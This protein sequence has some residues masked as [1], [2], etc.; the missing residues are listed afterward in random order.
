MTQQQEENNHSN[1]EEEVLA[2][3]V[4][5]V[6]KK[7]GVEDNYKTQLCYECRT[8]LSKF[9]IPKSILLFLLVIVI[10]TIVGLFNM[11]KS[12]HKSVLF[13]K[14]EKY[15]AEKKYH[16]AYIASSK[17][18][19]EYPDDIR[20]NCNH[21]ISSYYNLKFIELE[22]CFIKLENQKIED[23]DLYNQVNDIVLATTYLIPLDSNINFKLSVIDKDTL[24]QLKKLLKDNEEQFPNDN[25]AKVLIAG[26][27]YDFKLYDLAEEITN[28][29]IN[30]HSNNI[31]ALHLMASI[32]REQKNYSS[33][34]TYCNQLLAINKEDLKAIN[35]L[36]KNYLKTFKDKEA[37]ATLTELEKLEKDDFY[38]LEAT[39]LYLIC[40]NKKTEATSILAKIKKMDTVEI[41][42]YNIYDELA[43]YLNTNEKYR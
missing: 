7:I 19:K 18:I 2:P 5:I 27:C 35:K 1:L 11:P 6:C 8:E 37:K 25:A 31:Y 23:E 43:K 36:I 9:P 22:K 34:I 39:Y 15:I 28:N 30:E 41:L 4:C 33:S 3:N 29:L 26:S 21:L 20:A 40:T 16:S 24:N 42:G 38:T 13:A 32:K 10:I 12:L 14:T 17:L